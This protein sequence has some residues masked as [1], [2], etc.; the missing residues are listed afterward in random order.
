RGAQVI[1]WSYVTFAIAAL[2]VGLRLVVRS[3]VVH[4]LGKED[5]CVFSALV[6]SCFA[7]V[8]KG[9][10]GQHYASLNETELMLFMKYSYFSILFYNLSLCLTKFSILFLCLRVFAPSDWRKACMVVLVFISIYTTW[11]ILVSILSCIPIPSYWDKS[12]NGWCFPTA[13]LWWVNASLNIFTDFLVVTLPI[14]GIAKLQLPMKQKIGVALVFALGFFV[15]I[16][17]I[18]RLYALKIGIRTHDPTY[19]N[20]AIAIWS[21]VEVNGAIVGACLPT[22]KPLIS[23]LWPRLLSSG[24]S[25]HPHRSRTREYIRQ[26]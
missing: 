24:H 12:I 10:L 26:G 5:A 22:L 2:I 25:N 15:C 6:C 8:S 18:V 20:Y 21:V 11:V 17:S 3:K 7:C 9:G 23:R 13:V 19:D 14:P 16:I 1:A 4:V